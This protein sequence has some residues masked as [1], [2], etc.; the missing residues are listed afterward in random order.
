MLGTTFIPRSRHGVAAYRTPSGEV[1]PMSMAFRAKEA[2][3]LY[4]QSGEKVS[5]RKL[6]ASEAVFRI[7]R[8]CPWIAIDDVRQECEY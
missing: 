8:F 2:E 6:R 4:S 5:S 7:V 3:P 1:K